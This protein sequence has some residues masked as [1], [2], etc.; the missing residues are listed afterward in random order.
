MTGVWRGTQIPVRGERKK[1]KSRGPREKKKR[2][3]RRWKRKRKSDFSKGGGKKRRISGQAKACPNPKKR[4]QNHLSAPSKHYVTLPDENLSKKVMLQKTQNCQFLNQT[5]M[6]KRTS[7]IQGGT[8]V[9]IKG[10][11]RGTSITWVQANK[12]TKGAD[13]GFVKEEMSKTQKNTQMGKG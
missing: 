8:R 7:G 1:K 11:K 12:R 5:R 10:G 2:V 13:S 9:L 6:K 3:Q 4:L